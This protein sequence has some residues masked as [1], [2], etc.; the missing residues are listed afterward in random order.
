MVLPMSSRHIRPFLPTF[1]ID[2]NLVTM[3]EFAT[4]VQAKGP[5]GPQGEMYLDVQVPDNRI[6]SPGRRLEPAT[7]L[8]S[9]TRLARS[10]GSGR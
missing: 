4:F 8:C 7:R 5:T 9:S 3:A 2:R 1:Y 6:Q 10:A